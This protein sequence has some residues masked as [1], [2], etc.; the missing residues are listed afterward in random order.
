MVLGDHSDLVRRVLSSL[1]RDGG[2]RDDASPR[3]RD[4]RQ[5]GSGVLVLKTNMGAGHGGSSSRYDALNE[6]AEEFAFALAA[7]EGRLDAGDGQ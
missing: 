3:L 2:V 7:V 5:P 1:D 4:L 6:M